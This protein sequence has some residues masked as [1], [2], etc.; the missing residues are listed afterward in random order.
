MEACINCILHRAISANLEKIV[1]YCNTVQKNGV[2]S[3]NPKVG[4]KN[5]VNCMSLHKNRRYPSLV[6]NEDMR[7]LMI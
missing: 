4:S 3:R 6:E 5:T 2:N 7:H 1:K